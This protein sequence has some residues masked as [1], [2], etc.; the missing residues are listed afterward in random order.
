MRDYLSTTI[1]AAALAAGGL[2]MSGCAGPMWPASHGQVQEH[3]SQASAESEQRDTELSGR[4]SGVDQAAKDAMARASEAGEAAK[5]PFARRV[6]MTDDSV[7]FDASKSDLSA[8][9]QAKL[10]TFAEKLKAENQN[11]YIE[12]QGHGDTRGSAAYNKQLGAKRADAVRQFLSAQGV[13]L[14]RMSTI[15]Y[16]EEQPKNPE[17]GAAANAE[18]RRVVLIVMG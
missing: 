18:N 12:I 16:G 13:P 5:H 8:D 2:T 10:T 15:S 4:V 9:A 17:K 11:V 6:L 1:L 3:V 7:T 14:D